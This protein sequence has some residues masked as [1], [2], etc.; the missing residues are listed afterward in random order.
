MDADFKWHM[1]IYNYDVAYF[2]D[3]ALGYESV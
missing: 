3:L 2:S 1:Y